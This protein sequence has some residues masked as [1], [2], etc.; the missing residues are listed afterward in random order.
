M[1]KA[2]SSSASTSGGRAP[3]HGLSTEALIAIYR[4]MLLQR[5]LDNRGFQ[6]N[7]QGKI[8]FALGSEGHE[9]CRPALQWHSTAARTSWRRIIAI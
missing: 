4:Y 5:Y 9:G 3:A 2:M 8:P 6:L 1:A 7:R